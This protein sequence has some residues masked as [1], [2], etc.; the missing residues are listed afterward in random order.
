MSEEI[1]PETT[2]TPEAT[3]NTPEITTEEAATEQTTNDTN[4]TKNEEIEEE[5]PNAE[6]EEEMKVANP[7]NLE[8]LWEELGLSPKEIEEEKARLG[9]LIDE[10]HHTMKT[11]AQRKKHNIAKETDE[12]RKKH[13]SLLRAIG[14]SE[15]ECYEIQSTGKTGTIRERYNEVKTNFDAFE[16]KANKVIQE[17]EKLH[18]KAVELYDKIGY[19]Q[20]ERGEFA[21][22][23]TT[24]LSEARKK[25][26]EDQIASLEE[27]A[28]ER[29]D[30]L[31][32]L[33]TKVKKICEM[34][35]QT[36]APMAKEI[37][38]KEDISTH[39]FDEINQ[40]YVDISL[41]K[42]SRV[43]QMSELALELT[44]EW[45]LL[46]IS[47]TE[48]KQFIDSHSSLSEK[49]IQ[50]C[51]DEVVRLRKIHEAKLPELIE[52]IK[53]EISSICDS[54]HYTSEDKD[55]IMGHV[56][57]EDVTMDVFNSCETELLELRKTFILAQPIVDLINQRVEIMNEYNE[58]LETEPKPQKGKAAPADPKAEKIK[59]RYKFVLPRI[60]K[61]LLIYL[62]QFKESQG[63]DF[64][65]DG[66]KLADDLSHVKVTQAEIHQTTKSTRKKSAG[67]RK[68]TKPSDFP[69]LNTTD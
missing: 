14:A 33:E 8:T 31:K 36:P 40:Y 1:A 55:E 53:D 38:E 9:N 41:I 21:T 10:V 69:M 2:E 52:K 50:D 7:T 16:P 43:G 49:S 30:A 58:C 48:R 4:E 42:S 23:G 26:F 54:L 57:S 22:V 65:W 35:G 46:G 3:E 12:I 68:S 45:D 56:K 51:S 17:F 29:V 18:A 59:R 25:R 34:L 47:E 60:E 5:K 6:E 67:G 19:P 13:E 62:L 15:R 61:K 11:E 32:S 63:H 44:R 27:E 24:D 37:F 28:K 39:A 20:S 64:I 66:K